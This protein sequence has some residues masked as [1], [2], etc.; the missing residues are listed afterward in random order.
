MLL[1]VDLLLPV[2]GGLYVIETASVIVQVGS[3]QL[4]GRRVLRM[5]PMHH[6]LELGGWPETTV[7]IRLWIVNSLLVAL[8]LGVY[9]AD[10]LSL[11]LIELPADSL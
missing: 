1:H 9:Y 3:F 4:F 6:H 2:I 10:Y 5:A 11:G 8:A 7:L